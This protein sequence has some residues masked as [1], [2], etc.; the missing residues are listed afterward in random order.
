MR[1][2]IR[3]D[4][5]AIEQYKRR[6]EE[7]EKEIDNTRTRTVEEKWEILKK[8]VS[9]AM[10]RSDK[11]I[12]GRKTGYKVWWD[13][14]CTRKKRKVERMLRKW[15]R[16]KIG[17]DRLMEEKKEMKK[18]QEEKREEKKGRKRRILET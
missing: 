17:R 8:M 10:L 16:G 6:V 1:T 14:S 18:W 5:K 7:M 12:K 4:E 11:E 3:W 15:K 9:G 13:R 2:I